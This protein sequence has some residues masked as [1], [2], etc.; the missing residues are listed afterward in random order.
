V[1]L[2][3]DDIS[4]LFDRHAE[5]LLAFFVRR[6]YAPEVGMDLLAETF[7]AAFADRRRFRGGDEDAARAW[8]YGIA[9]H[10]LSD[11]FRRGR[12]ERRALARLGVERRLLTD[13]E[14]DRIEELAGTSELRDAVAGELAALP[15]DQREALRLRV[16]EERAYD[17][18]AR[19]LGVTEQA[20]RARVSRGL[21][22]L[23]GSSAVA[24]LREAPEHA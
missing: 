20:A 4:G 22:A 9:R 16:V 6:T 18:V 19:R 1:P 13:A 8:V 10:Q 24:D 2:D 11:Y 15:V 5:A 17:D 3:A 14:Y 23:R 7:A 21:R 12:V